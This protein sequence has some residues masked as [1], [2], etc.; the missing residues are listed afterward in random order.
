MYSVYK[1]RNGRGARQ[2]VLVEVA[3]FFYHGV[4]SKRNGIGV[5]V[6]EEYIKKVLE[7][8]RGSDRLIS[9]KIEI[10][11]TIMNVVSAYAPQVGCDMEGKEQFWEEMDELME[12]IPKDERVVI[13][14][15]FN[16]HIGS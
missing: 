15:D 7:V 12:S 13:G 9:V 14:A 10:E 1:K 6:R 3:K 16:G 5:I 2:E 8:K 11:G 4:D